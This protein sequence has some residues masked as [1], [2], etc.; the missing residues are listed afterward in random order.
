M[1]HVGHVHQ[2]EVDRIK[3]KWSKIVIEWKK[4][5]KKMKMRLI[6]TEINEIESKK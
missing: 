3:N 6:Q 4:K 5:E 2:T 1:A